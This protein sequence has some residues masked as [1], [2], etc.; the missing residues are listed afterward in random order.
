MIL[1]TDKGA[2]YNVS[3][4]DASGSQFTALVINAASASRMVSDFEEASWF[5]VLYPE[6]DEIERYAGFN[7]M[8]TFHRYSDT[9]Y[10][11]TLERSD[12]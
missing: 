11:I 2:E 7:R 4:A 6:T 5:M 1:T 8:L 12:A 3:H 10:L 9:M